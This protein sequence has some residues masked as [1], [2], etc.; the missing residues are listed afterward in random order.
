MQ[1][2]NKE[3]EKANETVENLQSLTSFVSQKANENLLS[4]FANPYEFI[5]SAVRTV[6]AET[7]TSETPSEISYDN[8]LIS[9][10]IAHKTILSNLYT[11]PYLYQ[12]VSQ[13]AIP[14]LK[15]GKKV[16]FRKTELLAWIAAGCY[17]YGKAQIEKSAIAYVNSNPNTKDKKGK[18]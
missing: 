4:F 7:S 14:S 1:S 2:N 11:K 8:D 9:L 13:K 5:K 6:L 12:L 15:I 16:M 18:K 17:D 3:T 10:D